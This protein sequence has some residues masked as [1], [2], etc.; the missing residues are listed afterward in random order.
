MQDNL[1]IWQQPQNAT[2]TERTFEDTWRTKGH[3]P[4]AVRTNASSQERRISGEAVTKL[5]PG[6]G[7]GY[8]EC[9]ITFNEC[10]SLAIIGLGDR[11][12]P[13]LVKFKNRVS[14]L[15]PGILCHKSG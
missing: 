5:C 6:C 15:V 14:F 4:N 9:E 7:G 3:R 10:D 8:L 12:T 11:E 2:L 1:A 13:A